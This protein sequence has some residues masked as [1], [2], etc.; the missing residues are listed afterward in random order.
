M[1]VFKEIMAA[2]LAASAIGGVGL[3]LQEW[4]LSRTRKQR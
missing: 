4:A 1:E 2:V 3:L